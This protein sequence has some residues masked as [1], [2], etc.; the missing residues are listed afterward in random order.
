MFFNWLLNSPVALSDG[1]P[2]DDADVEVEIDA[3]AETKFF[4]LAILT[5]YV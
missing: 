4:I 5:E 2:E 3:T 1:I